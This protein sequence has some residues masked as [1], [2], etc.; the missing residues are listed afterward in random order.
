MVRATVLLLQ[1]LVVVAVLLLLVL[2]YVPVRDARMRLVKLST[3]VLSS[4]LSRW[5]SSRSVL[6]MVQAAV[7]SVLAT[8]RMYAL[9]S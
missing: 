6:A 1:L 5:Y 9:I 3:N 8:K 7:Y 2:A 4:A